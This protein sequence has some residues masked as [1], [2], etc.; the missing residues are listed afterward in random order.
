MMARIFPLYDEYA[1]KTACV[2][3]IV[4]LTTLD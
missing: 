3:P 4:V 1:S 2:I